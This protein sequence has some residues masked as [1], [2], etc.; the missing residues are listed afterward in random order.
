MSAAIRLFL[1]TILLITACKFS[2]AQNDSSSVGPKWGIDLS[3]TGMTVLES[4]V[5][6]FQI[7]HTTK[8]HSVAFGPHIIYHDLFEGQSDWARFGAQFTYS[9]FPIRSNR[10][11][12]PFLFYD[13]NYSY[14]K[15]KRQVILTAEDGVSTYGAIREIVTNT[16]TH[17]FGIGT[18][19]NVYKGFFVHLGLSGGIA[20]F[21]DIVTHRSLQ[22]AYSDTKESAHPFSQWEPAYM[23]RFGIGYQISV[24]ELKKARC[25]D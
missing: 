7:T 15:A 1:L 5:F 11:F 16:L 9:Y 6:G 24:K 21:G 23:F 20:T 25:C 22:S 12:S 3:Y 19:I 10:L 14:I 8:R 18:R 13:L 4:S 17:H 2:L